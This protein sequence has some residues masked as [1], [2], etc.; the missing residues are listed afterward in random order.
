MRKILIFTLLIGLLCGC[1]QIE[2][3]EVVITELDKTTEMKNNVEIEKVEV[4][5][6]IIE[7]N[8]M[9]INKKI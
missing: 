3:K 7:P 4:V 1:E 8:E 2:K 9:T 5:Y 6:E